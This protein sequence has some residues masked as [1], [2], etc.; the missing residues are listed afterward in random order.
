MGHH[1]Y[2]NNFN[3]QTKPQ[4]SASS[5]EVTTAIT[6]RCWLTAIS[7]SL[8]IMSIHLRDTESTNL[9][10]V[11]PAWSKTD[12]MRSLGQSTTRS[13]SSRPNKQWLHKT[14]R[15]LELNAIRATT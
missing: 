6:R 10:K 7:L 5:M 1:L 11:L 9:S 3:T 13:S 4:C 15:Q 8:R 2:N 12:T 14:K